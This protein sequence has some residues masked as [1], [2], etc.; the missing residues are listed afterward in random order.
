VEGAEPMTDNGYK[1][2]LVE[3]LVRRVVTSLA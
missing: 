3:T 1:V 2:D